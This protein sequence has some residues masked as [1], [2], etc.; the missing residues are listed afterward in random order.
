MNNVVQARLDNEGEPNSK[1]NL[2]N[3]DGSVK[4]ERVYGQDRN[5]L[6]DT[7]WNHGGVRHVF[8]H[9]HEGKDGVRQDGVP[10][11]GPPPLPKSASRLVVA[12]T[13]LYWVITEGSR[14]AFPPRNLI[15]IA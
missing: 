15:P 7:D 13:I 11:Q 2:H 9:T 1:V 14:V 10:F 5:P 6:L 8:P 3:K 4:Q 12:G